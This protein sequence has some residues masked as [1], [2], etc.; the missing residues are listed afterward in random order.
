M[1][2]LCRLVE[3]RVNRLKTMLSSLKHGQILSVSDQRM[4]DSVNEDLHWL[5]LITGLTSLYC[6]LRWNCAVK[7]ISQI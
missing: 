3:E 1:S 6:D 5:L 4:L 2:H 7:C